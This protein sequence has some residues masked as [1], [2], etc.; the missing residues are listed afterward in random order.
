MNQSKIT[1]R[2]AK[3]LFDVAKEK[4][5]L[6]EIKGDI[7][8][9]LGV[10]KSSPELNYLLTS[11][12]YT[13]AQKRKV[14]QDTF[15]KLVD[16]VTLSFLNMLVDNKREAFLKNIA[17]YFNDLVKKDLGI[18]QVSIKSAAEL[19]AEAQQVLV[20]AVK[21]TYNKEVEIETSIDQNLIGGFVLRIDD[22]ELDASVATSLQKIKRELTESK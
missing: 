4:N 8:G 20:K 18:M 13:P 21:K 16:E 10:F 22:K 1:V 17:L 14:L 9:I 3:A 6:K 5:V 2:Y 12:V 11:P 15:A 19:S 7:Q